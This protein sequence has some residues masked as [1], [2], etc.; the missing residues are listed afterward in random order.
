M[1]RNEIILLV[2]KYFRAETSLEEEKQLHQ[3]F[4]SSVVDT[5]LEQYRLLFAKDDS[6]ETT[7]GFDETIL[8]AISKEEASNLKQ[9]QQGRLIPAWLKMAASITIL[10]GLS[11]GVYKAFYSKKPDMP[12]AANNPEVAAGAETVSDT[13]KDPEEARAALEHALA[14]M[15]DKINKGKS[16][17]EK[18]M[19]KLG[20]ISSVIGSSN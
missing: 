19:E 5:G 7:A 4:S 6:V 12:I 2:E 1:E 15:S 20:T 10:L 8:A 9:A 13:Y 11:I 16:L 14:F 17:T 18:P 3:Y